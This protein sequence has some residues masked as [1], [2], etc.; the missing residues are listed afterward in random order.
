MKTIIAAFCILGISA[1]VIFT[2][3]EDHI[4][5]LVET[6]NN[7]MDLNEQRDF[8]SLKDHATHNDVVRIKGKILCEKT[9]RFYRT[10]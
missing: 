6:T 7:L 9:E 8:E 10:N 5:K 4:Y 2:N 1:T 3:I